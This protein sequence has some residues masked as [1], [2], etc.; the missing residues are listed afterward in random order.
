MNNQ[1]LYLVQSQFE[2]IPFVDIILPYTKCFVD[3]LEETNV[4]AELVNKLHL[5][6]LEN[7]SSAAEVTLQEE[8]DHFRNNQHSI[9]YE[10]VEATNLFLAIK[11]PVLDK[12]L[13]TTAANYLRHIQNIYSNFYK[14]FDDILKS[15][16][17]ISD[18]KII[19]ED[20]DISLGDGHNGESTA[21]ITLSDGTKLI[22]KPRNIDTTISYNLFIEWVNYKLKIKLKTL[23]CICYESYGWLE[24]VHYEEINSSDELQEYY[25]KAGI[26]SA[27]TLLLGSKD[28]HSENIIA[29]GKNPVVI[30]HE[31][32][33]QPVL[34][35]QSIRT[36]DEQ[37][38]IP[39]FSVLESML[40]VNRDTGVPLDCA[41]Y[42]MR[43]NIEVMELEK[44][45]I[46]PNSIDSKR[47]TRF[48]FRKLIKQNIPLFQGTPV[49]VDNY[50]SYFTG[51]FSAAYD[52]FITS[53][54]EL[55]SES[56]PILFFENQK[57]R[58]VWRPT[59][60]YFRILKYMRAACFMSDF[61][62]YKSK[63]Y[64]LMSKAY[65]KENGKNYKLILECEMQQMLKGDIPFFN[66]NSLNCHL[67]EDNSFDI[68]KYNCIENIRQRI[69][70]LS[71]DHK[72]EQ[73]KY[74]MK[75][76]NK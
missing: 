35:G 24:F 73:L 55:L 69:L 16:S 1:T 28:C 39:Y 18:G 45:V 57:I 65:Q 36:W 5:A 63:I 53:T 68:F 49:F 22:Y 30:D 15:F 56:S 43:G 4:S 27:V 29:S 23:K 3:T 12:I 13:K 52:M 51:G 70:L 59:F 75:W 34:S 50:N 74:I 25:Y 26:L 37:H 58:Y 47:D 67:E 14:D 32:I 71:A 54:E 62:T 46:N 2:T 6:L 41:G 19:I 17:I 21:L 66:L 10:F 60:I 11:Y 40:I 9:Y 20:I 7:L 64:E 42:G 76:I 48:A 31:T 33:I 44:K 8:L 61:D 38:K 72:Q